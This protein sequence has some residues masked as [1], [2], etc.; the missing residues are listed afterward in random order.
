MKSLG[1]VLTEIINLDNRGRFLLPRWRKKFLFVVAIFFII[2]WQVFFYMHRSS[3]NHIHG[4]QDAS[5][6]SHHYAQHF[7]YFY[8]YLDLFPVT[9]TYRPLEFSEKGAQKVLQAHGDSLLM[10]KGHWS[11]LGESTRLLMYLPKIY[12]T[13]SAENPSVLPFN[14]ILFTGTLLAVFCSFY[15]AGYGLLGFMIVLFFG[16]NPFLLFETYGNENYF[17]LMICVTLIVLAVNLRFFFGKNPSNWAFLISLLTGAV[18]GTATTIRSESMV[19]LASGVFIYLTIPS[20]ETWRKLALSVLLLGSYA[21]VKG[22]WNYHFDNKYHEAVEVV[23][24]LG[25]NPYLG[26]RIKQHTFWHPVYCGL[27]DFDKKY[28]YSWDDEREAYKY[29]LPI[30]KTK[31]NIDLAYNNELGLDEYYDV[32]QKYYKKIELY[33]EYEEIM[34]EKVLNNILFDKLWYAEIISHRIWYVF[35]RTSPVWLGFGA[36]HIEIPFNGLFALPLLLFLIIRRQWFLVK[37]IVFSFPLAA[38][39]IIIFAKKNITYSTCFHLFAVAILATWLIS[40][41]L[42]TV[43]K[44]N[45][46]KCHHIEPSNA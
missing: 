19:I 25:G 6:F 26:D 38:T 45:K 46:P 3:L 8:H 5:G 40:L 28:G 34:K 22:S 30:L 44:K 14:A 21:L 7:I 23:R 27:A 2:G 32:N 12:L 36:H 37:L 24:N 4:R 17:T 16:S 11:R 41:L 39:S 18:I 1:P 35:T 33:P 29:A 15:F 31:Y 43:E 10:E 9:T 42:R 13:G 20:E